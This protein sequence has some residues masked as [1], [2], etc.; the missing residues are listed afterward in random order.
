[1]RAWQALKAGQRCLAQG[2]RH[3]AAEVALA[4]QSPF[5]RFSTPVPQAYDFTSALS[6]VPETKV[7]KLPL[8]STSNV[9]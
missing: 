8:V 9:T 4:E 6:D 7:D 1:M 3:Y 5:L 2:A